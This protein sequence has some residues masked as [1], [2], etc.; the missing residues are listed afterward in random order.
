ML[1]RLW[2][3]S[4]FTLQDRVWKLWNSQKVRHTLKPLT[5]IGFLRRWLGVPGVFLCL[6]PRCWCEFRP[7]LQWNTDEL[8][9]LNE[10]PTKKQPTA[11]YRGEP[12]RDDFRR[13]STENEVSSPFSKGGMRKLDASQ[14]RQLKMSGVLS[15]TNTSHH[16]THRCVFRTDVWQAV[17]V[18]SHIFED[19]AKTLCGKN[20][21]GFEK[22]CKLQKF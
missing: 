15:S 2:V 7:L 9:P 1:V 16:F 19:L 10:L 17:L 5:S 14:K 21:P 18:T 11:P 12:Q 6:K 8:A 13:E 22:T 20:L 4:D 3:L